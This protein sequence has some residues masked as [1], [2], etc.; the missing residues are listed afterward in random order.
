M[1]RAR[2]VLGYAPLARCHLFSPEQQPITIEANRSN[3][4][5]SRIYIH[6]LQSIMLAKKVETLTIDEFRTTKY[7]LSVDGFTGCELLV[8]PDELSPDQFAGPVNIGIFRE[9][10][11]KRCITLDR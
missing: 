7:I 1:S 8:N 9:V 6:Q 11:H 5:P 3:G 4:W 2:V 10:C